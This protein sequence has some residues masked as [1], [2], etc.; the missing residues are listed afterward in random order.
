MILGRVLGTGTA[1][2]AR[3]PAAGLPTLISLLQIILPAVCLD[4]EQIILKALSLRGNGAL[5]CLQTLGRY[6]G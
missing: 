4:R 1:Q 5:G 6:G 3:Y 2:F